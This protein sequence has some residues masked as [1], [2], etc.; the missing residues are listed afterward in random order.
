VMLPANT[1]KL[2]KSYLYNRKFSVRCNSALSDEYIIRAGVPQGS[3][4]GPTLYLIYTADIPISRQ[5]T[6]S[7]FA[8]DTAILS[9]SRCPK[10]ATAQLAAHLVAVEKWLSDWRIE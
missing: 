1:H 4:L 2:L 9:R 8:D 5:L 6:T 10:Q 7:T 3:V